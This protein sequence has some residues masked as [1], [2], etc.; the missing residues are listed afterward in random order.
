MASTQDLYYSYHCDLQYP[1]SPTASS[2]ST[3]EPLFVSSA[4]QTSH[5]Y[6]NPSPYSSDDQLSTVHSKPR[7]PRLDIAHPYARLYAKKEQVKRRK[8]WNHAL[9]K[10]L[11]SPYELSTIGAPHRRTIYISSLEAHIDRLHAQLLDIGFWPVAFNELD[12]YKGLNSKTAKSIVAGLQ[13]DA[14][15]AKLKLLELERANNGLKGALQRAKGNGLDDCYAVG[16]LALVADSFH[17]LN[18]VM[19]LLVALY[20]IKLTST[21]STDSRYSYGWH[22]AEILAALVNGVFLLALCFS[23]SLEA[24]QRFF[25]APEHGHAHGHPHTKPPSVLA[26]PSRPTSISGDITPTQKGGRGRSRSPSPSEYSSLYGHPAATRASLVQTA[27]EIALARSPSPT[28]HRG[29]L[30]HQRPLPDTEHPIQSSIV[31]SPI[32]ESESPSLLSTEGTPL[33]HDQPDDDLHSHGHPGHGHSHAGSMNM[34]ALVLHV[35][36][37]ALGNVGVIATGLIIWLT[38]WTFKNYCDPVISL[39]ITVIIFSS[40]LPLV[41]SASFIL[42]QGVPPTISLDG[43]R[44]SILEVEGVLSLHELHVWQLSESKIIASVHVLASRDHDFMPIAVKIRKALHHHG[45]HSSTI[46]PEYHHPATGTLEEVLKVNGDS[47][48]ILCPTDQACD[49]VENACC[50]PPSIEV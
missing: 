49:P 42:L 17:M 41:R 13:H 14:S 5:S 15:I 24:L 43:V 19:S 35:M 25:T 31:D 2:S 4:L 1:S 23:I 47:C 40:A 8:I 21:I 36:G 12:P 45:I 50:P 3:G 38:E 28:A 26:T 27:N 37:D 9:E 44:D 22:R 7:P 18:D 10:S 33:L 30:S 34:R 16:S 32:L 11:F 46:Q 6:S 48:L 39:V 29:S 20:A